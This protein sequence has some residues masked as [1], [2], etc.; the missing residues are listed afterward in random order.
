M[1]FASF[2]HGVITDSHN[3]IDKHVIAYEA[4]LSLSSNTSV[5]S[6]LSSLEPD[7]NCSDQCSICWEPLSNEPC[8][9]ITSCSH[10][11]HRRC[12]EECLNREPKCPICRQPIGSPQGPC[13]SGTM[14]VQTSNQMCPGYDQDTQAIQIEYE[15][16]LGIQ[17]T[18]HDDPGNRYH[19]TY[20]IAFLPDTVEGRYLLA[21]LKYAWTCGLLFTVG[22]SLTTGQR[23]AIVWSSVHH[24]TS[25]WGGPYSFPDPNYIGNCNG[26]LDALNV[27][28]PDACLMRLRTTTPDNDD[29]LT[30][31]EEQIAYRAPSSLSSTPS[32]AA[33]LLPVPS[34]PSLAALSLNASIDDPPLDASIL[35]VHTE[36][37]SGDCSVCLEHYDATTVAIKGCDHAF[38]RHCIESCLER[39]LLCPICRVTIGGQPQG[40]SPSGIMK[41][42]TV[43]GTGVP[44]FACQ[45]KIL[46][47]YVVPPGM[48]QS[49]HPN[50]GKKHTGY[51]RVAILPKDEEGERLL[52]RLKFAWTHGLVFTV[53]TSMQSGNPNSLI[54][55]GIPH[56]T[57][58]FGGEHGYPDNNYF[59]KCNRVLDTLS[60]PKADL[61]A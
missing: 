8:A 25:L 16:P 35:P 34:T 33:C 59:D 10:K 48:Q 56:K 24:K 45:D 30:T 11:Y 6:S 51:A 43:R 41:V 13:P 57:S 40:R 23:G 4:P 49:Y 18:Y 52:A 44:G 32:V 19:P 36:G 39:E 17:A 38:H 54:W 9:K 58:E 55:A 27:P 7:L 12:I 15:M 53:G 14:T 31:P 20:R 1:D 3:G 22:T 21:R 61:C 37:V 60:V 5:A 42:R 29:T 47:E 46:V 50:P 2:C 26:S 28:S